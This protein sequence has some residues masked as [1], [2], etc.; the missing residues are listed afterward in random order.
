MEIVL[1]N[2][3]HDVH[4]AINGLITW[5][6]KSVLWIKNRKCRV[7]MHAAPAHFFL[8]NLICNYGAVIHFR[9]RSS[10]CQHCAQWKR[11]LG[12]CFTLYKVPHITIIFGSNSNSFCAVQYASAPYCEN[13]VNIMLPAQLYAFMYCGK[14]WIGFYSREFGHCSAY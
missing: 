11:V 7:G 4:H 14:T 5:Q 8:S 6:R 2:M 12:R 1:Q 13:K 10:H 9:S 3:R